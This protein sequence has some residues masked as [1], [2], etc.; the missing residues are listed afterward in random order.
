[1]EK[2]SGSS[3]KC[4][5]KAGDVPRVILWKRPFAMKSLLVNGQMEQGERG[6]FIAETIDEA[7]HRE[8]DM[9]NPGPDIRRRAHRN[10]DRPLIL[11]TVIIRRLPGWHCVLLLLFPRARNLEPRTRLIVN[12]VN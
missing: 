5:T 8:P 2:E 4:W 7:N 10:V 3:T 12:S 6:R 11:Q 1:M 9:R